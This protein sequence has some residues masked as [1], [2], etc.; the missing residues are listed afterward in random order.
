MPDNITK[1]YNALRGTYDLG[2]EDDFRKYLSDS[3][4]REAL[5]K[6]LQSEYNTGDEAAF[7]AYLGFG[8]QAQ[9]PAQTPTSA[10]AQPVVKQTTGQVKPNAGQVKPAVSTS[11]Q[12]K[13]KQEEQPGK[14][15]GWQPT[16][17]QKMG[18]QMQLDE[19]MRQMKQSQQDFS[20]RMENMRKSNALGNASEMKFN[21][22]SGKMER[23]YYTMLGDEVA[24][25][26]EQSR[27][28]LKYRDEWEATT[29][30]GQAHH[31][32]RME[33][34]RRSQVED[35][36]SD[37]D[38]ALTDAKGRSVKQYTDYATEN[39][40]MAAMLSTA[41]AASPGD[42]QRRSYE[43]VQRSEHIPTKEAEQLHNE[44]IELEAAQRSMRD[45]KRIIGEAD[46]N[47]QKGT[48]GKWLES[49]FA[50]GAARGLRQKLFDVDTWDFGG[51]DLSDAGALMTA[52]NA[53]DRGEELT[54]SQQML[55]D[56]KA[57]ELATDAYFGSE[58]GHGY[59]A[60]KV[61][62]ESIPFM[63]EMCINPAAGTGH[64][65]QAI[66]TRY[67]LKRFGKQAVKNNV[68]KYVAAKIGA[69]VAGDVVG[70]ATMS[71][72][73][74]VMRTAADATE[75]MNG[76]VMF[77]TDAQGQS[78][79]AGHTDGDDAAT[80]I[81]KAFANTT[82][83][84]YSE[85]VGEY[86]APVLGAVGKTMRKGMGNIGLESVNRFIDDVAANNVAKL[87]RDFEKHSKWNGMIGEYAE[88]V[89]GGIMNALVVGDQTL[90]TDPETGVFNLDNNIDTF[91]GVALMGG[92]MSSVKAAGYRTP[93]YRAG[94]QVKQADEAALKEFGGN[95]DAWGAIRNTLAFGNDEDVRLTLADV[96]LNTELSEEQKMSVFEYSEAVERYKGML[97]GEEKNVSESRESSED[98]AI[99]EEM[100]VIAEQYGHEADAQERR[101]IAIELSSGENAEAQEAWNGVVQRISE[102][103]PR[104][105]S[106]RLTEVFA[107][108]S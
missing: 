38:A 32:K 65:A 42:M 35:L 39:P 104:R 21:P 11:T 105:Y 19:T 6:E 2:S 69:R 73:T 26:L 95:Q 4:K 1:L 107:L 79:F 63:L 67:A 78:V 20:T 61:T 108:L 43:Q 22:G 46:H 13:P 37:I 8:N 83:E 98:P 75:R 88:E 48:F 30:E 29:P 23:R 34:A 53:Y 60:G 87:V 40:F 56:A 103:R 70:A 12:P 89:A 101:D 100:A 15:S 62:A 99:Q 10:P 92:F 97:K 14:E 16:L 17:R 33:E 44:I 28:N 54:R 80:A 3:K 47:A 71:A 93:K 77:D 57:V 90:D 50:G 31:R 7:S 72:T 45:A 27:L 106:I 102:S 76:Q 96:S 18:M 25:P 24:T 36:S 81:A 59:K 82:I 68:K 9:K 41:G 94:Q 5:R 85:M 64:A 49:S 52:L 55:L 91:L 74:G 66:M 84:N 86:F 51:S 58:V